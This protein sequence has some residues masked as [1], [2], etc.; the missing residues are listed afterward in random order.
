MRP[1]TDRQTDTQTRV[2]TMHFASS[3][4]RAKC[5]NNNNNNNNNK[6]NNPVLFQQTFCNVVETKYQ[7]RQP[8][9][10]SIHF[11]SD[12][13]SFSNATNY[14]FYR[15]NKNLLST[16]HVQTCQCIKNCPNKAVDGH[17]VFVLQTVRKRCATSEHKQF[18][19]SSVNNCSRPIALQL[20]HPPYYFNFQSSRISHKFAP[21]KLNLTL[22]AKF[23]Y[24]SWFEAGSKLVADR[25]EAIWFESWSATSFEPASNQLA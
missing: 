14:C 8:Q 12:M 2:T 21:M 22:K 7:S 10:W 11:F 18:K 6:L 17:I 23:H 1:R 25:F 24:A 5:N 4:T 9:D 3:T 13:L 19:H 15:A 20:L 16:E